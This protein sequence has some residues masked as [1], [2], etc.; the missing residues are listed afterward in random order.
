[1]Q[2]KKLNGNY[3]KNLNENFVLMFTFFLVSR[4][5]KKTEKIFLLFDCFARVR[6][7]DIYM[8]VYVSKLKFSRW[9]GHI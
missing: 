9:A 4:I 2:E 5:K 7:R 8:C 1:M 6:G 3:G